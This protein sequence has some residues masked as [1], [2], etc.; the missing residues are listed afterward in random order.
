MKAQI[1]IA[2]QI[3]SIHR[4]KGFIPC[5]EVKQ[6]MFNTYVLSFE[7]LT[8]AR[9]AL[10]DAFKSMRKWHTEEF[11][12]NNGLAAVRYS[13]KTALYYEAAAATIQA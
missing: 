8:E 11:G 13:A 2:G 1:I 5:Y 10:W 3:N 9:K 12:H 7:S 4:I 6:G